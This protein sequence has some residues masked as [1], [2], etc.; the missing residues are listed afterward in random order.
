MINLELEINKEDF[1]KKLDIKDGKTPVKGI[2]YFDG[3]D[4]ETPVKGVDYFDGKDGSPDTKEQVRDK[5]E[6]LKDSERLDI[7]AIKGT[8][9]LIEEIAKKIAKKEVKNVK[10]NTVTMYGGGGS[11]SSSGVQSVVAGTNITVDNTDP[12]NPIV[13][14]TGGGA[15]QDTLDVTTSQSVNTNQFIRADATNGSITLTLI[16]P[17]TKQTVTIKKIDSTSNSVYVY[18]TSLIDGSTT[19]EISMEDESIT[20]K[21]TGTTYDIT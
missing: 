8:E 7:S 10:P 14:S 11:S 3:D 4:G 13:S 5:L 12:L 6:E 2:D 1:K 16:N 21:W 19:A 20:L 9:S 17:A 18:S 15:E